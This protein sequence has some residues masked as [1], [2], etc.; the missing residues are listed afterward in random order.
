MYVLG[1]CGQTDKYFVDIVFD[2]VIHFKDK[3][4]FRTA[5]TL[6]IL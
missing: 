5:I 6:L 1:V 3:S 4:K 2:D